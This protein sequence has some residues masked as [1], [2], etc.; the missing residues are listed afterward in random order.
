MFLPFGL[1]QDFEVFFLPLLLAFLLFFLLILDWVKIYYLAS[2]LVSKNAKISVR[3]DKKLAKIQ[4]ERCLQR[5]INTSFADIRL[6]W[7]LNDF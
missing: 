6:C 7:M 1:N 2:D 4:G 3:G 5:L